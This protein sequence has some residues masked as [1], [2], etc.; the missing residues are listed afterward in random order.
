MLKFQLFPV[1]NQ[2]DMIENMFILKESSKE[3]TSCFFSQCFERNKKNELS[4]ELIDKKSQNQ[5]DTTKTK[6][7]NNEIA[8]KEQKKKEE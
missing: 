4:I 3:V 2:R 5:K 1:D 8:I 7:N 6:E